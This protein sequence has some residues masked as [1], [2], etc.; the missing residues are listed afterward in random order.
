MSQPVLEEICVAPGKYYGREAPSVEAGER[1]IVCGVARRVNQKGLDYVTVTQ[2][3]QV[4]RPNPCSVV[5]PAQLSVLKQV[6]TM[7]SPFWSHCQGI[8]SVTPP[9]I[10]LGNYIVSMHQCRR[11]YGRM[12]THTDTTPK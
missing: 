6:N 1:I 9:N 12:D 3:I 5:T 11:G 4:I 8:S 10:C 7:Q 2:V